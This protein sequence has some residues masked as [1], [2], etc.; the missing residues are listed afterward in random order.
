[1]NEDFIS[2]SGDFIND[3]STSD[4]NQ[5]DIGSN[6]M[7]D[8]TYDQEMTFQNETLQYVDYSND[9]VSQFNE[10]FEEFEEVDAICIDKG[11]SVQKGK[12]IYIMINTS[13]LYGYSSFLTFFYTLSFLRW[14]YLCLLIP[15]LHNHLWLFDTK[16]FDTNKVLL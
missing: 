9:F 5:S 8:E 6:F 12:P 13:Y 14:L 7:L 3:Y 4:S 2:S 15:N 10:N 11:L 16:N 1:M